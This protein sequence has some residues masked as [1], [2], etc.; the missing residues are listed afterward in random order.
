[1][2]GEN[3]EKTNQ[4]KLIPLSLFPHAHNENCGHHTFEK[5]FTSS[6]QPS[7]PFTQKGYFTCSKY[8]LAGDSCCPWP[9]IPACFSSS[10]SSRNL[11]AM[12]LSGEKVFPHLTYTRF[13][14]HHTPNPSTIHLFL[15]NLSPLHACQCLFSFCLSENC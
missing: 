11:F 10:A 7:E 8:S 12:L 14:S 6:S 9:S 2:T 13:F 4:V 5:R 1:M 3:A 15:C